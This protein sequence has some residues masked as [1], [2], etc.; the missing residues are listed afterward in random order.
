MKKTKRKVYTALVAFLL[1]LLINVGTKASEPGYIRYERATVVEPTIDGVWTSTNEWTEGEPTMI[2]ENVVFRSTYTLLGGEPI[3]CHSRFVI[4]ILNDDT[5][6]AGDYWQICIDGYNTGGSAPQT[7]DFRIDIVGHTDL[8]CYQGTGS[9]WTE[10]TPDPVDVVFADSISESPTSST[11][12]WI[13]EISM[14]KHHG[15]IQMDLVWGIRVAVYDES[16]SAAGVQAWPPT[17]RDV[18]NDWGVNNHSPD[19]Y[20]PP[21]EEPTTEPP[22]EEPTTAPPTEEP[23]TAPPTE[24]PTEEPTTE[25]PTEEPTTEPPTEPAKHDLTISVTGSGSTTLSV[26]THS[27]DYG[28]S[29]QIGANPQS[30]WKFDHW[31][32]DS[33]NIGSYNPTSVTMDTNHNLV[34]VFTEDEVADPTSLV[35]SASPNTLTVNVGEEATFTAT[36]EGGTSP[37]SFYWIEYGVGQVWNSERLTISK[38]DPGTYEFYCNVEDSEGSA[39]NTDPVKL[40]V[41]D[42]EQ[43]K[44]NITI[45]VTGAG[46]TVPE[47]GSYSI[48]SESS[49]QVGALAESG[50]RF[51]H[52]LLDSE[53]VGYFNPTSVT[54]DTNH[55]L[56]VVFIEE[57][58]GSA[59]V[60]DVTLSVEVIAVILSV[61]GLTAGAGGWI[62]RTQRV[63]KRHK[64][65]F[66]KHMEDIDDTYS[67]FRMNT[68]QCETELYN[69]KS[70]VFDDFKQGLLDEEKYNLLNTRIDSYL[71]EIE[72]KKKKSDHPND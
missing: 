6:D 14:L 8:V 62:V 22:T 19:P 61:C 4:E 3:V 23:T 52:W 27:Y 46:Q 58:T 24:P 40:I 44:N 11:P 15:V 17:D 20:E 72:E 48:D 67:R 47:A 9:G 28:T 55:V 56:E 10:I 32:L 35:V 43:P 41:N 2:G 71:R 29:V 57:T 1:L 68:L 21:T 37:Y 70:H 18:P 39:T 34:A 31:L 65:L 66:T 63:R 5:N 64:I 30:G 54:M 38:S 53:N 69:Y 60:N 13:L 33:T 49:L 16:N 36:A 42:P 12:H 51:D 7:D 26:G 59:S 50:W 25:P 45:F